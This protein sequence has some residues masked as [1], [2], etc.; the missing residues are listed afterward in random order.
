[1]ERWYERLD[2]GS[3]AELSPAEQA[4]L[5]AALWKQIQ[6]EIQAS[7]PSSP[8]VRMWNEAP[9]RWAAAAFVI[10]SLSL[11]AHLL[12][13]SRQ[14]PVASTRLT[15]PQMGPVRGIDQW[16]THT[17]TTSQPTRLTLA[18]GSTVRLQPRSTL[19]Y[20]P[21]FMASKREVHL[22]GEAFF[23][24]A[25]NPVQPFLV[26]TDKVVTTVLGTSFTVRA[27]P[28]QPQALVMVRTG[29]VRVS[30][31]RPEPARRLVA[32]TELIP[33]QQVVYSPEMPALRKELVD[34]PVLLIPHP[35]TFDDRPV[36]E[37]IQA[38]EHAYGV[39]IVYDA[40]ALAGCSVRLIFKDEP[41]FEKLDLLCKTLGASYERA[42]AKIIFH[43]KGCRSKTPAAENEP[44][45]SRRSS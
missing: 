13:Q 31:R 9:L 8:V 27:Y 7:A 24:V 17:N 19:R 4:R 36:T 10:V 30:P 23:D 45:A 41:L 28:H 34:R 42:G 29:R 33:N 39:P 32:P 38:L 40:A 43:S 5:K 12:F 15:A 37:V 3:L 11:G 16:T 2:A 14:A 1:M 18:D 35:F 25:R 20:P 6:Q 26:V 44:T 22:R 21:Q